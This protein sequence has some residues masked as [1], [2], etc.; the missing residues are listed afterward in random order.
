M[1]APR[2]TG[3]TGKIHIGLDH[4]LP[5]RTGP[6]WILWSK[7]KEG[8]GA[9]RSKHMHG[10]PIMTHRYTTRPGQQLAQGHEFQEFAFALT[11]DW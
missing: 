5:Q 6:G 4:A 11:Q 7:E 10:A 8:P 3:A 2:H 1:A 9:S